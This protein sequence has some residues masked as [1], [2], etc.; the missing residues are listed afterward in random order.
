MVV[1]N[2]QQALSLFPEDMNQTDAESQKVNKNQPCLGQ[3]QM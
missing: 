1:Y 2:S 3:T